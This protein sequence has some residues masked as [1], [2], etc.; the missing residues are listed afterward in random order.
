MLICFDTMKANGKLGI[1]LWHFSIFQVQSSVFDLK[2]PKIFTTNKQC[3]GYALDFSR[4]KNDQPKLIVGAPKDSSSQYQNSGT[5]QICPISDYGNQCQTR[6]PDMQA[7]DG[8]IL[9]GQLFGVNVLSVKSNYE[10]EIWSCAPRFQRPIEKSWPN[11]PSEIYYVMNGQ[12]FGF[13]N[14]NDFR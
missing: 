7:M 2:F 6:F 11:S 5:L 9:D 1:I 10:E 14:S 12:C 8:D 3:F 13:S 4:D